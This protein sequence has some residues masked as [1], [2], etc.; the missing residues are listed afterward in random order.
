MSGK[1]AMDALRE[2]A[3]ALG[4]YVAICVVASAFF[5]VRLYDRQDTGDRAAAATAVIGE[6]GS[7]GSGYGR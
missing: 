4:V 5:L 6:S 7:A 1:A 3:I 2:S